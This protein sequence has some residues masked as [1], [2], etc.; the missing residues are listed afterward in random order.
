MPSNR[1]DSDVMMPC[2]GTATSHAGEVIQGA[3]R[4][5]GRTRRLLLSLPAPLL[6]TRAEVRATPGSGLAI[7]PGCSTKAYRMACRLMTHLGLQ[8]P[9]ACV[10]LTTNIPAGKGCGSSTTDMLATTRALLRYVGRHVP[11][12]TVARLLVEVEEASDGSALSR[13]ALFRHREGTVEEYLPGSFP[14]M[15]VLVFDAQPME[16]VNTVGLARARY[17]DDQ[18]KFFAHLVRELRLAFHE[19]NALHLARIATLSAEVS[20]DFLPKPHFDDAV[21][22]VRSCGGYGIAVSHSG[23]VL[24]ALLPHGISLRAEDEI[25]GA[26]RVLEMR[27][28][29][30]YTIGRDSREVAWW[31]CR[32]ASADS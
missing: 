6:W 4:R 3:V 26:A 1:I 10:R 12:E 24:A 8:P 31:P 13:P 20:Q 17:S 21:R 27:C 14:A 25:V 29:T 15:R 2:V 16:T 28:L 19:G 7:E 9:E 22:L 32:G 11:E 5:D 30:R 23:T 18:L